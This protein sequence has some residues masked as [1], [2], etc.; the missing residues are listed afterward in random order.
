VVT[1]LGAMG[2]QVLWYLSRGTGLVLLV[3]LTAVVVLGVAVRASWGGERLHRFVVE[4]M[5]RNLALVSVVL[6]V[7]HVV[8]AIADPFVRIGW[9]ATIVPFTSTYRTLWIGLGTVSVDVLLLVIVTSLFRRHMHQRGW[10]IVHWLAYLAWP[11]AFV[12]SL[13]AGD[14]TRLDAVAAL[15]WFCLAT[16]LAVLGASLVAGARRRN[17]VDP[18]SSRP[19]GYEAR[20][21]R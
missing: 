11:L 19:L 8:T 2:S 3:L 18:S 10:R 5:H 14:D 1:V 6:L 12:H 4:G 9:L 17:L 15:D 7:V 16:V 20:V 21:A 13:Y